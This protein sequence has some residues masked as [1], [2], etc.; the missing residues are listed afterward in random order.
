M[1]KGASSCRQCSHAA[2]KG[3]RLTW[4]ACWA[5]QP[6]QGHP[7]A[8][9]DDA[10]G[11]A[12]ARVLAASRLSSSRSGSFGSGDSGGSNQ[13]RHVRPGPNPAAAARAARRGC[14]ICRP[15]QTLW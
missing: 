9:A 13:V 12:A 7:Q 6:V 5:R 14:N 3:S 11:A 4:G 2:P 10:T 15:G 8:A 1:L